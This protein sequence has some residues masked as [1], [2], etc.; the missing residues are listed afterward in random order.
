MAPALHNDPGMLHVELH[1]E[2]QSGCS[3][4]IPA[5]LTLLETY[6]PEATPPPRCPDSARNLKVLC[7]AP[8]GHPPSGAAI[9]ILADADQANLPVFRGTVC[10]EPQGMLASRLILSGDCSKSV[11]D[12]EAIMRGVLS[13]FRSAVEQLVLHNIMRGSPRAGDLSMTRY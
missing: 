10:A 9:S 11:N 3:F 2:V 4:V 7:G 13:N 12:A 5:L 1:A 8:I 6:A